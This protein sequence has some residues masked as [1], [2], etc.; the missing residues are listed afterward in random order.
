VNV[1]EG[2]TTTESDGVDMATNIRNADS[3][4]LRVSNVKLNF[5][6]TSTNCHWRGIFLENNGKGLNNWIIEDLVPK[7]ESNKEEEE[8]AYLIYL[9]S[10]AEEEAKKEIRAGKTGAFATEDQ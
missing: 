10:L 2:K 4:N 5:N 7:K 3:T 1:L 8:E 6:A 9:D